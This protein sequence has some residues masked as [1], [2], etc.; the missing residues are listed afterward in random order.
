MKSICRPGKS[1][2]ILCFCF[3]FFSFQGRI[4]SQ[5]VTPAEPGSSEELSTELLSCFDFHLSK[6]EGT[7]KVFSKTCDFSTTALRLLDDHTFQC[8]I[9][10]GTSANWIQA[11]YWKITKDSIVSF[12]T[13]KAL[14]EK[15]IQS[16]KKNVSVTYKLSKIVYPT[17]KLNENHLIPVSSGKTKGI[18]SQAENSLYGQGYTDVSASLSGRICKNKKG[19]KPLGNLQIML[20]NPRGQLLQQARTDSTG[21][22]SFELLSPD[23][24]Y[25]LDIA[26]GQ[27]GIKKKKTYYFFDSKNKLHTSRRIPLGKTEFA[28]LL[29][30]N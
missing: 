2:H 25:E 30:D 26:M 21:K 24:R 15:L 12:E 13:D 23:Q 27:K 8:Q 18:E 5:T 28:D 10:S 11:G 16:F 17:Y 3:V 7:T 19:K 22:F 9:Q 14:S 6:M 1:V 4:R 29:P 20:F